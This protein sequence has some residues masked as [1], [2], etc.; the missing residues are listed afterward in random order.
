MGRAC[1]LLPFFFVLAAVLT[2]VANLRGSRLTSN[3]SI[4]GPERS[5]W[6]LG[7]AFNLKVES[8]SVFVRS[9]RRW[10]PSA[11]IVL[12][13][14]EKE[15]LEKPALA[16]LLLNFSVQIQL[17]QPLDSR[18][19]LFMQRY[20]LEAILTLPASLQGLL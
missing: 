9:W 10:S 2:I 6:V 11:K 13:L 19:A 20:G 15:V 17:V 14:R 12:F 7:A 18:P 16:A 3:I 4:L 5:F 1:T 8:I